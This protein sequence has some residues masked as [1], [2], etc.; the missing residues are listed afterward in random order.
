MVLGGR[1]QTGSRLC[2]PSLTAD[3]VLTLKTDFR[4]TKMKCISTAV[5]MSLILLAGASASPKQK[6][7]SKREVT[8]L[9]AKASTPAEHLKLADYYRIRAEQLEAESAEHAEMAKTYRA[10]PTS[11]ETKRPGATD[12]ASHCQTLSESLAKAAKEARTLFESHAEMAKNYRTREGGH[13]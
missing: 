2:G 12:T 3:A 11:S 6:T 4:R 1:G 5:I 13:P 9:V 7:L 10:R 8:A